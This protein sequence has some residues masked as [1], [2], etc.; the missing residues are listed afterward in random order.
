M[1][2]NFDDYQEMKTLTVKVVLYCSQRVLLLISTRSHGDQLC[3]LLSQFPS[4]SFTNRLS[5]FLS[6]FLSLYP[7]KLLSV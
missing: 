7:S 2:S 4:L 5:S 3:F 1:Q 6:A